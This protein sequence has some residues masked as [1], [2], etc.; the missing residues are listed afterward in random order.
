MRQIN[1]INLR[2]VLRYTVISDEDHKLALIRVSNSFGRWSYAIA[3][4]EKKEYHYIWHLVW[5]G[6]PS[7]SKFDT[8]P[9]GAKLVPTV[10]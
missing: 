10:V 5:D 2:L 7:L 9:L 1:Y 3:D 4:T 6:M 8:L